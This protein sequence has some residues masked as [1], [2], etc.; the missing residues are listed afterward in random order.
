LHK[1]FI[2]IE[3]GDGVGKSTQIKLLKKHFTEQGA[4]VVFTREP[5]GTPIAE[6]IRNII[7]NGETDKLL[8][9]TETLLHSAC[10]F[11]HIEKLIKPALVDG[12]FVVCDRFVDSTI[13]YQGY[14]LQQDLGLIRQ[15][16]NMVTKGFEP[17]ITFI[18]DIDPEVGL[19]RTSKR[20]SANLQ[21]YEKFDLAFHQ[22][23]R[24]GFLDVAQNNPQRCVVIDATMSIKKVHVEIVKT[25][26]IA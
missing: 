23:V 21:R 22:R 8:P 12:Q 3:G 4:D 9:F 15:L 13:A 24:Q 2:S 14:G 17:D 20:K 1:K 18:L 6:E 19:Q 16:V 7:T 25:L 11:E 5:G 26:A 10:R